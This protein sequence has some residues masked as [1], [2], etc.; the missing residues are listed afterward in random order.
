MPERTKKF[1]LRWKLAA[2]VMSLA[3]GWGIAEGILFAFGLPEDP[4]L[5]FLSK[6]GSV[7]WDCYC[8]N[9]RGYFTPRP[10]PNGETIYCV[11]HSDD[12]PRDVNLYAP[13]N[14][15]AYKI[16]A[17]GDSFTWGL[18]VKHRDSYPLQVSDGLEKAT[19]RRVVVAN[20]GQVGQW[21]MDTFYGMQNALSKGHPDLCIYGYVLNDPLDNTRD[22]TLPVGPTDA[23]VGMDNADIDDFIN[24]RTAN[25]EKFRMESHLGWV[26]DRSRVV[27]LA[28]RQWE[29]RQIHQRTLAFY[30]DLYN[31][32]KNQGGL[33][34]TW[35]AIAS[36]KY[37]QESQGKRFLVVIFPLFIDVDGDYPFESV[38]E[39][40]NRRL[41]EMQV[42]HLDLL[43]VYRQHPT[44]SLWVHPL[45]RHPN[46]IAHRIA[47]ETITR[48][49]VENGFIQSEARK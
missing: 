39:L 47:A 49:L 22:R 44:P 33:E 10:G 36:M 8:T 43:P 32:A 20:H 16:L 21:V 13:E 40:L 9:P 42:E 37:L 31:P 14:A 30:L 5:V 28:L 38:H 4:D 41:S 24:V 46:E 25:L 17:V 1:S 7:E 27:D 45:D 35:Q 19:G 26:R 2:A 3:A 15:D 48:H 18:G 34:K 11:D 29:W 6:D 12:P 23:A